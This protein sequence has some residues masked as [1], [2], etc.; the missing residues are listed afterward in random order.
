MSNFSQFRLPAEWEPLECIWLTFPQ[1]TDTWGNLLQKIESWYTRFSALISKSATVYLTV[2][3]K[4]LK[5]RVEKL[6][7]PKNFPIHVVEAP[8]NDCWIRDYGAL[9]VKNLDGQRKLTS[10]LFNSWGGKYP[11]FDA[12]NL[13]PQYMSQILNIP[14]EEINIVLEG[15]SIDSNGKGLLLSSEQCLLNPNRNLGMS[16]SKW[17][18][19][20]SRYFGV[21]KILWLGNGIEGDDTDGHVDELARF[22]N[23]NTILFSAEEDKNDVNYRVLADNRARLE[24]YASELNLNVIPVPLPKPQI[25]N[26]LRTPGSYMN[27]I[28]A[29]DSVIIPCFK[30][31]ADEKAMDIFNSVFPSKKIEPIEANE[32]FFGQGGLHCISMQIP[33]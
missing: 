5:E 7:T 9:C 13:I 25:V 30:D 26:G 16:K 15:G 14:L 2:S 33:K 17:D 22:A 28:I 18:E 1:N 32:I 24:K 10:W 19:L 27:F 12:D 3:T 23:S 8:T 20:A 31:P 29:N 21:E 4:S 6:V 11:P